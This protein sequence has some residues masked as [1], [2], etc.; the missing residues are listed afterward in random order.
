MSSTEV[1]DARDPQRQ[2]AKKRRHIDW[3]KGFLKQLGPGLITGAA[4]DDPS[5]IA[6]YSQVGAK[7]QFQLLWVMPLT[8]PLMA[9]IQ[10]ISA[11]IGRVTG[12]GIAGNIRRC[13]AR[14][15]LYPTVFLLVVANTINIGADIGAM[16][17][18]V[19]LLVNHGSP[20]L[21]A[22]L[23]SVVCVVMQVFA[24]YERTAKYLKWLTLALFAY[25]VTAFVVHT[26]WKQALHA[27]VVPHLS[28]N[29]EMLASLIAVLGTTISPYLFFWQ[30]SQ[31]TEEI[32]ADA[33][34]EALKR[35][36][37]QAREQF[38]RIRI[39]TYVGMTFSNLVAYFIILSAATT[40]Y[41]NGGVDI[42]TSAQA[43]EALRPIAGNFAFALFTIGIIGTGLLA[44][45][46]LAGSAAYAVGEAMAWPI[47][48]QRKFREARGFYGVIIVATTIGLVINIP[49]VQKVTHLTPITALFWSAVVN[50]VAAVPIMFVIM[51]M[52]HDPG[53]FGRFTRVSK[54]LR[55]MGW[56]ATIAMTLAAIGLLVTSF[57]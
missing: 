33:K 9:A 55:L 48:L 31:E 38:G 28:V 52:C 45:P 30:A 20:M 8:L 17:D 40:I 2:A 25:V 43:A 18:A 21:Y 34:A 10:E 57:K 36:P 54:L 15:L 46:V 5:G 14:W 53:L 4:D 12:M 24:S 3:T 50:G 35:E 29:R 51:R 19:H 26:P 47:G 7:Y 49:A 44:V 13:Y 11:R 23:F 6:T 32:K 1:I 41:A 27:T 22:A 39:D 16:G 37:R 42:E 56:A